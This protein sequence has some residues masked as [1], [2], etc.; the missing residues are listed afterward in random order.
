MVSPVQATREFRYLFIYSPSPVV[1]YK[2][3][4]L[5]ITLE[6]APINGRFWQESS[7]EALTSAQ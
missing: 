2:W 1:S 7:L 5:T 3:A 4:I 6:Y